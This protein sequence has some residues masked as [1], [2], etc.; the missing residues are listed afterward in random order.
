MDKTG[1]DKW[2]GVILGAMQE[3][4]KREEVVTT[5]DEDRK[6]IEK[7]KKRFDRADRFKKPYNDKNLRMYKLYRGYRD[8]ANYAYNTRIMPPIGFEIIETIKPRLA[9][10]KINIQ[11]N[12]TKAGD[13]KN[14]SIAVWDDLV[15]YNLEYMEFQDLK[16]AWIDTMLKYGNAGLQLYWDGGEDGNPMA[17]IVDNW[18]FYIDPSAKERYKDAGYI[19]KRTFK[20]IETIKADEKKREEGMKL[21]DATKLEKIE[22]K[23]IGDDPRRDRYQVNTLKMG[24]IDSGL[25][26]NTDYDQDSS[27][28][29]KE[30]KKVDIWECFDLVK[31]TLT[32]IM[33]GEQVVR[34]EDSV[35]KNIN[36][37]NMFI[38]LPDIQLGWEYYA[39]GHLEPVETTIH[40]I[41]DSRNQAM[42]SI[43]FSIDPIRK[44]RKGAGINAD[45]IKHAPGAVWE[46]ANKDDVF[47]E[48][49][50]EVSRMW[51]EKDQLLRT[52]I[53]QSLALS[54][55]TQGAPHSGQEPMGKVD[56]LLMQ[57]NIRF[58]LIVRQMEIS[59]T[60]LVNALIQMNREFLTKDKL[61]RLVGDEVS[62]KEFHTSDK[63]VIVDAKVTIEPKKE[64]T[65]DQ[66][67]REVLELYKIFVVDDQ[68]D[69]NNPEE[70][71][72]YKTKKREFQKM[73]L[74]EFDKGEY[75]NV[76]LPQ[77]AM[78][79]ASVQPKQ[80]ASAP[81]PENVGGP[82][83]AEM[84][85][86]QV[87]PEPI[88]LLEPEAT[89]S[90]ATAPSQGILQRLGGLF[91]K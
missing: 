24:Q 75:E 30:E 22:N 12:P 35:Y 58:S 65:P 19:I 64:K 11:I 8:V 60:K 67:E 48:R 16:I 83:A 40:E 86:Q 6:I 33:N 70:V 74:N 71:K 46:L 51:I 9:A 10:A 14:K 28:P 31:G 59:F 18:L 20:D 85:V 5:E 1:V 4:E 43:V 49:P 84:P 29:D 56:L 39:M 87:M 45:D 3:L 55:Y 23:V 53:Q 13:I 91:K 15:N 77:M 90:Q 21:Y 41:A 52:E 32:T 38:D 25:R 17:E 88:P 50:P 44:V 36:D 42:D 76:L 73:I 81:A 89:V 57:S 2:G 82:V 69:P 34:N 80:E 63:E 78:L 79:E 68:P 26:N 62:F 66:K 61:F 27:T 37:G 47:L 7:W 54:E 72:F